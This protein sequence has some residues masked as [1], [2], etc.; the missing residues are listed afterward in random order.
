M[1]KFIIKTLA[2][3]FVMALVFF[4]VCS[5]ANGYSDPFYIRFTT[6]KQSSLILGTSRAAQGLQPKVFETI[7]KKDISNYSFTVAHS[8]F[9]ATYLNSIKKK[10]DENSKNGVFIITVDPWSL[11]SL[12]DIPDDSLSFRELKLPLANTPIVNVDPNIIYLF[13]NWHDKYYKLLSREKSELFLHKDGWLEVNINLDSIDV[14]KKIENKE[15]SYRQDMLPK[16]SFS[17]NRFS[18]LKRTIK[19]LKNHG[20]VYLV[21]LPIHPKIMQ[22]ENELM[23][24]FNNVINDISVSTNGYLDLTNQNSDFNYTDGNHLHKMSGK[25]VSEIIASWIYET[26][27]QT[28]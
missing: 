14:A 25:V 10:V 15:K 21:R 1:K 23:P 11:S 7:L 12:T 5:N 8:P 22:I 27:T 20:D 13:K 24:N 17:K 16:A 18:Y 19:F 28:H 2:F 6:P 3:S 4:W 26:M 9:G